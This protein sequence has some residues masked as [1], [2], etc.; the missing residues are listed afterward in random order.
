MVTTMQVSEELLERLRVMKLNEKESY[1]GI[2]W[3]LLEDSMELSAET[4]KHITQAEKEIMEGRVHRWED[5]VK[6]LKINVRN[7]SF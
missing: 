4:K 1:E 5:V 3:D 2:I 7:N 6:D